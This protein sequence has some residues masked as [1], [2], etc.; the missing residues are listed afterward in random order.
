MT[1]RNISEGG[2]IMPLVHNH[3]CVERDDLDGR[4]S[5]GGVVWLSDL[6]VPRTIMVVMFW[7]TRR[8]QVA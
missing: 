7:G 8:T 6:K 4:T 3:N 2:L 1:M 5:E